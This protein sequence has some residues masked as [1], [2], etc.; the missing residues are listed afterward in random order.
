[1]P[2]D[3]PQGKAET[4]ATGGDL[5]PQFPEIERLIESEDFDGINKTLSEAYEKLEKIS[6]GRGGL[7]KSKDDRRAMKAIE[8]V[9]DLLRELLKLKYQMA[10]T[11][12]SSPQGGKS[13][14]K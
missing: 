1:M 9:M 8:K 2:S 4:Q 5:A 10:E 14:Q 13:H 7:G 3:N 6:A 11:G 12:A